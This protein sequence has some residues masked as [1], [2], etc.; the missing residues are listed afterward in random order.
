[1][2]EKGRVNEKMRASRKLK[3]KGPVEKIKF[4]SHLVEREVVISQL[5]L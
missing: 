1:M 5:P 4:N 2:E 3:N